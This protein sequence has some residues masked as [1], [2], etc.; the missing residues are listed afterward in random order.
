MFC[1]KCHKEISDTPYCQYCGSC[2][3]KPSKKPSKRSRMNGEGTAYQLPNGKWRAEATVGWREVDGKKKRIVVTK[4]GFKYKREALAAL[5]EISKKEEHL[6]SYT[7]KQIYDKWSAVHFKTIS[8]DSKY[9][10]TSAYNHSSRLYNTLFRA[11]KTK[12]LQ[13]AVD[14]CK[15]GWR[16]KKNMK[17]LYSLIYD[18]AMA[19]DCCDKNY[20][21]Y[22]KLPPK[23]ESTKDSF[24]GEE[25]KK[26]WQIYENGHRFAGYILIMIYT[27]MRYG[28]LTTIQA[29]NVYQNYMIGGIKTEA[30]KNR[31][32]PLADKIIPIVS[33]LC[34]S[35]KLIDMPEKKFYSE[36]YDTLARAGIRKLSPHS[37]R[38]TCATA[39]AEAGVQPAIISQILGHTD[40]STTMQY[41][42]IQL[43]PML[44][45]VNQLS[46]SESSIIE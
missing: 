28:E 30:G 21:K 27:G 22:I 45:A 6:P 34:G 8:N 38:H 46:S 29:K 3:K 43:S 13:D 10:Y 44:E 18:Y 17:T 7:F 31:I 14:S 33:D 26:I 23:P 15:A 35:E 36:Y 24:T 2:Q 40:Y 20:A 5:A 37:C 42:H 32:I 11:I 12:E 9:C 41:T 1:R 39:L 16:T 19:N 4:S 25:I